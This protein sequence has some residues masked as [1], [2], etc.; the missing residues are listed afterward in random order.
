MSTPAKSPI[1]L[2]ID[3]IVCLAFFAF[4][5]RV[6]APHVTSNDPKMIVFFGVSTAACMTGVFWLALQMVKVVYKAQK[7]SGPRK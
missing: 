1:G 2:I 6:V 7:A 5:Y 4:N 3:A